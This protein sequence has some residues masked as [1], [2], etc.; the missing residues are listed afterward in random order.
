MYCT[1]AV[2]LR[3]RYQKTHRRKDGAGGRYAVNILQIYYRYSTAVQQEYTAAFLAVFCAVYCFTHSF[4]HD[5]VSR[6][7]SM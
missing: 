5:E 6:E 2:S 4:V 3:L 1:S 7:Q